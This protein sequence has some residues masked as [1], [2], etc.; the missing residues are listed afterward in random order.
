MKLRK[1]AIIGAILTLLLASSTVSAFASTNVKETVPYSISQDELAQ[2][3]ITIL[4]NTENLYVEFADSEDAIE[5][6]YNTHADFIDKISDYCNVEKLNCNNWKEFRNAFYKYIDENDVSDSFDEYNDMMKFFDIYENRDK[7]DNIISF[8]IK[9]NLS[10]PF[11]TVSLS[12][13]GTI[14]NLISDEL[15]MMLPSTSHL[16]KSK[17]EE[18]INSYYSNADSGIMPLAIVRSFDTSKGIAYAEKYAVNR[19]TPTYH[20]FSR[21]DCANFTSQIL[22]NGGVKQVVYDEES[23]GWWHKTTKTLG[24]TRHKHSQAWSMAD[25]FAKYMGV[26]HVTEN[27]KNFAASLRAGDFIT[28]DKEKDGDWD[29]M[30]FV[31]KIDSSVGSYGYRDYKVAQHTRD[32][33]AWTSSDTNNWEQDSKRYAIVRR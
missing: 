26:S 2:R 33:H 16:V 31:T 5:K 18:I 23:K 21:G 11:S 19:N 3:K 25:G 7:N 30:A 27:H 20:S 17:N 9:N 32:Y 15:L 28:F 22:E 10:T 13:K 29:H 6:I 8:V 12:A 4:G 24:I 1:I 14:N